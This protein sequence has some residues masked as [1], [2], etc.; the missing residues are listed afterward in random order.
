MQHCI[1]YYQTLKEH[2][3]VNT[4]TTRLMKSGELKCIDHQIKGKGVCWIGKSK[5]FTFMAF[6]RRLYLERLT[7][8]SLFKLVLKPDS[9]HYQMHSNMERWDHDQLFKLRFGQPTKTQR[10]RNRT[11]VGRMDKTVADNFRLQNPHKGAAWNIKV[12]RIGVNPKINKWEN[13]RIN[14]LNIFVQY[15]PIWHKCKPGYR[16]IEIIWKYTIDPIMYS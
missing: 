15:H 4:R 10:Q 6:G 12:L 16:T 7:F 3:T 9:I 13:S 5:L 14:I 11:S 2:L 8:I 1:L